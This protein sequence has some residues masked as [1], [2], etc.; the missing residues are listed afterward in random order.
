MPQAFSQD[1]AGAS[2]NGHKIDYQLPY[3]G[4]LP[5]NPLYFLKMIRDRI[6]GFL[7]SDSLKKTEFNLLQSEKRTNAGLY[8]SRKGEFQLA[9]TT[10]SKGENYLDQAISSLREARKQ[11]EDTKSL[12]NKMILSS[13]KQQEV[14]SGISAKSSKNL[15]AEFAKDQQRMIN[16]RN[17][18]KSII[19]K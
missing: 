8:L 2:F 12:V 17:M 11:G 7:I 5:D 9:E 19:R 3:P 4:L 14:I 13:M 6:V 15:K 1:K 18:L 16:F 10:I